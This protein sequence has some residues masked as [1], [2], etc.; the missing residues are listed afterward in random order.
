MAKPKTPHESIWDPAKNPTFWY[1]EAIAPSFRTHED[2]IIQFEKRLE[3]QL[4]KLR[5]FQRQG[6]LEDS[7][8]GR[9]SQMNLTYEDE[10]Q[11]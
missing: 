4:E 7:H 5:Q 11:P 9:S 8:G 10:F 3:K 2:E 1:R 6:D